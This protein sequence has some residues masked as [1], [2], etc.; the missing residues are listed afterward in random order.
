MTTGACASDRRGQRRQG[1]RRHEGVVAIGHVGHALQ[2]VEVVDVHRQDMVERARQ[3]REES[4]ARRVELGRRQ[5]GHRLVQAA[6]GQPVRVRAD[7]QVLQQV[8]DG[9]NGP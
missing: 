8:H 6:V 2:G 9:Q 3:A 5:R 7:A 1:G 4:H